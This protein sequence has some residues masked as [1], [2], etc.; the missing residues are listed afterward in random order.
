[1]RQFD[2]GEHL[3]T[4]RK[5]KGLSQ[6]QAA[7]T[8]G[9]SDRTLS[10]WECGK[11]FPDALII[12]ALADL[13]GVSCDEI[14]R[15]GSNATQPA[16]PAS[17]NPPAPVS[18]P[19]NTPANPPVSTP[20]LDM[21]LHTYAMRS[22]ILCAII[23]A[24]LLILVIAAFIV[25]ASDT[26]S[27]VLFCLGL[28]AIVV[29]ATLMGFLTSTTYQMSSE[30]KFRASV[31][32][33][34]L[35]R[36]AVISLFVFVISFVPALF[37]FVI[38]GDGIA[39]IH[40]FLVSGF[41]GLLGTASALIGM[42]FESFK[43]SAGN[44]AV[45][46]RAIL[47][48]CTLTILLPA[49]LLLITSIVFAFYHPN[50]STTIYSADKETFVREMQTMEFDDKWFFV[51][52]KKWEG[53]KKEFDVEEILK[54]PLTEESP[55]F[56]AYDAG[57]GFMLEYDEYTNTSTIEVSYIGKGDGQKLYPLL[58]AEEFD[59]PDGGRV[60]NIKFSH[61]IHGSAEGN[62]AMQNGYTYGNIL[63][64]TEKGDGYAFVNYTALYLFLPVM[65]GSVLVLFLDCA[66]CA[67]V[68][69]LK[70]RYF[71]RRNSP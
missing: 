18:A 36:L 21:R 33:A 43:I 29:C 66:V 17:P 26:A 51:E 61:N 41:F 12:P 64:I 50:V 22:G 37:S 65:R 54:H 69:L 48:K 42:E 7:D 20:A 5:Q 40:L 10:A 39:I 56:G 71:I 47:K 31:K 25:M 62:A 3:A 16:S 67:T 58:T 2:I 4:L 49:A 63:D 57:D 6:K 52:D 44:Y 8:L 23:C 24:A 9:I 27:I 19:A 38:E 35:A 32:K 55:Y 34:L 45:P 14:L 15:G 11:R 53:G 60:F 1:M 30:V 70:K 59:L 13:Y 46:C 68:Y 28:V